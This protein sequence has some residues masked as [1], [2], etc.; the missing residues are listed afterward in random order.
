MHS[1]IDILRRLW[2]ILRAAISR[3][4]EQIGA[5]IAENENKDS[6]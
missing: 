3:K 2:N 1:L 6:E 4:A 5:G